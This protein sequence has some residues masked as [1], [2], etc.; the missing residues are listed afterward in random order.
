MTTCYPLKAYEKYALT[1]MS[2]LPPLM[3]PQPRLV[4]IHDHGGADR[5]SATPGERTVRKTGACVERPRS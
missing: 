5:G 1:K 4:V 2:R 3:E